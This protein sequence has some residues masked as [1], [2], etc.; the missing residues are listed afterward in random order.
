MRMQPAYQVELD[1]GLLELRV[2]LHIAGLTPRETTLLAPGLAPG[3]Y[4]FERFSRAVREVRA[5]DP[6]S[7]AAIEIHRH[8]WSC[9]TAQQRSNALGLSYRMA[10][11]RL[12]TNSIV[13][14]GNYLRVAP[15]DGPCRVRY[16]APEGWAVRHPA[17]A[18]ELGGNQWEYWDYDQL[19]GTPVWFEE[20][21]H[22][23]TAHVAR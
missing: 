13:L 10:A 3:D 5:F 17:G 6:A 11:L 20:E 19:L 9:Y 4:D 15:H 8:G 23:L 21:R 7:G 22:A 14:G 2:Q 18:R 16:A 1:P 12:E